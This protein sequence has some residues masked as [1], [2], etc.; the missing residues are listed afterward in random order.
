M[1]SCM[2][3]N[4]IAELHN[5]SEQQHIYP[6]FGIAWQVSKIR[7]VWQIDDW[8]VPSQYRTCSESYFF[9]LYFQSSV[10]GSVNKFV[11]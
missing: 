9:K 3:D 4:E 7:Y 10:S 2:A 8:P 1:D 5:E 6:K 11:I